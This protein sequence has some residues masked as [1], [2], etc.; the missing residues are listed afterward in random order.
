MTLQ[1][2]RQSVEIVLC[3]VIN[4]DGTTNT[5]FINPTGTTYS[6]ANQP[7]N[8]TNRTFTTAEQ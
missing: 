7:T 2:S 3:A 6:S 1:L 8:N 4:C 5:V